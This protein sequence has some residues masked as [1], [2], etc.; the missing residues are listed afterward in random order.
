MK[1]V[2][3]SSFMLLLPLLASAQF[4]RPNITRGTIINVRIPSELSS[5]A[6]AQ[7][8]VSGVV[9]EDLFGYD[10]SVLIKGGAPVVLQITKKARR[11]VGRP[12]AVIIVPVSVLA[13]DNKTILFSNSGPVYEGRSKRGAALGAGIS[14]G[15]L[16]FPPLFALLAIKGEDIKV[17]ANTI[18]QA[19]VANDYYIAVK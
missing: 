11:G 3:F 10:G 4:E 9:N 14:C 17:P 15:L 6:N 5:A 19:S 16:V 7:N 18:I 8:N 2:L 1:R 12:G 13:L